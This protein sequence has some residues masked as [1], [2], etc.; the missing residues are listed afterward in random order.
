[1]GGD[2]NVQINQEEIQVLDQQWSEYTLTNDKGMKVS[3]LNYGGIITSIVVPDKNG[4]FENVVISY[5]NYEDYLTNPNYFGALIG[6]VAGRIED[7][8]FELN[9]QTYKLPANEGEHHLHGGPSGFHQVIWDVTPFEDDNQVGATLTHTSPDGEGGYPGTISMKVTYTLDN[10]NQLSITYQATTDQTT[11]L[12]T[13]NHSYFNLSG[14]LQRDIKN[15][16]VTI[17]SSQFVELDE[18]LIPTGQKIDVEGTPFDF[19]QGRAIEDGVESKHPQN[20]VAGGG[21]DHYFILDKTKAEDIIV[22]DQTSGRK[23]TVKTDQPG[24]VMYTSNS[25]DNSL[26]LKEGMSKQHLAVCLETQDSPA[27]LHNEGFTSCVLEKGE[28]Y[29]RKTTFA[30]GLID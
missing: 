16:E 8:A 25:L 18:E 26:E 21:Y 23:L 1:M 29:E 28:T 13:T 9:G 2:Q 14:N 15:H 11:A 3:F 20:I 5:R 27:S 24:F 17:D 30:F 12:T 19:R 7:S 10:D 22:R 6:R 4:T